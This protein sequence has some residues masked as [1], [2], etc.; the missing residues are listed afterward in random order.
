MRANLRQTKQLL[1]S[2]LRQVL[3]SQGFGEAF[4]VSQCAD[5]IDMTQEAA[6][7]DLAV[8]LMDRES[9][10]ARSLRSAIGRIENGMYGICAECE[11]EIA[12]KRLEAIPWAEL[13]I[14]CQER[15]DE[16]ERQRE[17]A[18]A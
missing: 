15:A 18:A 17:L 11:G 13:C 12:P 14:A 2:R 16:R 10:L 7:R 8:E 6:D 1:E 5:M 3:A 9:V 4:H